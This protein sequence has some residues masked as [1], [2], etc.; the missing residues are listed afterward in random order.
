MPVKKSPT[1]VDGGDQKEID[2]RRAAVERAM[3]ALNKGRYDT[4][5]KS[6]INEELYPYFPNSGFL[7][8]L[9]ERKRETTGMASIDHLM[10][11]EHKYIY[12]DDGNIVRQEVANAGWTPGKIYV[13]YGPENVGKSTLAYQLASYRQRKYGEVVIIAETENRL[14]ADYA[15]K[16]GLDPNLTY[17]TR[18]H[19]TKEQVFDSVVADIEKFVRDKNAPKVGMVIV[20]SLHGAAPQDEIVEKDS[21]GKPKVKEGSIK[22]T[23]NNYAM[24]V[25]P[26][27]NNQFFRMI[28]PMLSRYGI[29]MLIIGQAR[30]NVDPHGA[31]HNLTGGHGVKH[32]AT[33]TLKMVRKSLS[34][35]PRDKEGHVLGHKAQITAEKVAGTPLNYKVILDYLNGQGFNEFD[36]LI[37]TAIQKDILNQ[38]GAWITVVDFPIDGTVFTKEEL[39]PHLK[40]HVFKIQGRGKLLGLMQDDRFRDWL[41]SRIKGENVAEVSSDEHDDNTTDV[42]E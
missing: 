4:Y 11:G 20:D 17:I 3:A 35:V 1:I 33:T 19:L 7:N 32:A 24:G 9:T 14:T 6:G 38:S 30:A 40:D 29:I 8:Q 28:N 41:V 18:L 39:E 15:I 12:D 26:K 36:Y 27:K 31:A 34:D 16:I 22:G 2:K 5:L 23:E 21:S 42:S 13:L 25:D 37:T 10:G